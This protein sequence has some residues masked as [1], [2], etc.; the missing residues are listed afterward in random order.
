MS[1]KARLEKLLDELM[2]VIQK[3]EYLLVEVLGVIE[4]IKINLSSF[5]RSSE[6][7]V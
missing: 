6:F 7:V 2:K 4:L 1:D 5:N 3:E